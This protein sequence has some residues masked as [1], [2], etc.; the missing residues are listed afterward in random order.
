M[1]YILKATQQVDLSITVTDKRGNPATVQNP[2]FASSDEAVVSV[3]DEGLTAVASAVGTP[4]TA[5]VTFTGDADLGE[6]VSPITGVL[7]VEVVAGDAAVVNITAGTPGR[8]GRARPG[9]HARADP[10]LPGARSGARSG[11]VG[12]K[13]Q[14]RR[15]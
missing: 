11:G 8:A 7:D 3:V 12:T 15:S 5:T 2:S 4:G 9:T 10:G 14:V 6:G 13:F 1:S